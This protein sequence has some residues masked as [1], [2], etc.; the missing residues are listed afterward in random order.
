[1]DIFENKKEGWLILELKG[2]MDAMTSPLVRDKIFA[3]LEQG[4]TRLQL[5]CTGLEYISS[6]GLRVLF[7][8]AFKLQDAAG[9]ICCYGVNSN[10]RKIFNLA[11]LGSEIP[12]FNTQ[13]DALQS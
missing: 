4:E 2:R 9:K 3:A 11:D 10:V 8:A 6:A 1:M 12:V 7:E 13:Q 5:D